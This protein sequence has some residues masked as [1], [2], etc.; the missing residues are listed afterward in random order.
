MTEAE[1]AGYVDLDYDAV[2]EACLYA[3]RHLN[4]ANVK[5]ND[6]PGSADEHRAMAY[7]KL[8]D[9]IKIKEPT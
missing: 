6:A 5:D 1:A 9:A 2:F 7:R 8:R 3:I 4:V